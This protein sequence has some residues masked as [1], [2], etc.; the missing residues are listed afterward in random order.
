MVMD[1]PSDHRQKL[2]DQVELS[3]WDFFPGSEEDVGGFE[4]FLG[5]PQRRKGRKGKLRVLDFLCP[6]IRLAPDLSRIP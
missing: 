2:K 1:I 5:A 6:L 3:K 4:H